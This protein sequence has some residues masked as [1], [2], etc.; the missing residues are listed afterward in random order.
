MNID[1]GRSVVQRC[2][3]A[4]V[5]V[6]VKQFGRC[7]V[8]TQWVGKPLVPI[9]QPWVYRCED[10]PVGPPKNITKPGFSDA[11]GA[12]PE[13][14]PADLRVREFPEVHHA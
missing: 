13:N 9:E 10:S 4:K 7:P 6:F 3:A 11:K 14:W 8:W 5:P 2:Q 1:W 12:N